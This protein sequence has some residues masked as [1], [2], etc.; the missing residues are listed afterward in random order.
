M[1]ALPLASIVSLLLLAGSNLPLSAAGLP[2]GNLQVQ[3]SDPTNHVWDVTT[4]AELQSP[5]IEMSDNDVLI[6]FSAPFT[7]SGAGKLSGAGPTEIAVESPIF[8]GPV[9]GRYVA[10]GGV[11]GAKGIAKLMLVTAA[12]GPAMIQGKAQTIV[13]TVGL[14]MTLNSLTESATGV[15]LATALATGHG[16][17]KDA[18]PITFPWADA[19]T[20]M[21]SGGWTL[22]LA[23]TNDAIKKVG[24]TA[25]VSLSTGRTL[26]FSAKGTYNP[27]NGST[28]L[29]L[30]GDVPSKGSSLRVTLTSTNTVLLKGKLTGQTINAVSAIAPN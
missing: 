14:K 18:G 17:A 1:K 9:E 6:S 23:L 30:A 4:I 11:T 10:N 15:Y 5:E 20:A 21:G 16:V 13:T 28:V 24:G 3:V 25:T 26:G 8:T 22:D 12:K 7:Q 29:V 19:T 2:S 27:K